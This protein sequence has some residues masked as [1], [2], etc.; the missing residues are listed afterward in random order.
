MSM[1]SESFSE[2]HGKT[3]RNAVTIWSQTF[4]D[5]LSMSLAQNRA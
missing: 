1:T 3:G 2:G 5:A 4:I